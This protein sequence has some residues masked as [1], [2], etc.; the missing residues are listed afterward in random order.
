MIVITR[1]QYIALQIVADL[2]PYPNPPVKEDVQKH[3]LEL[4]TILKP[5]FDDP[6]VEHAAFMPLIGELEY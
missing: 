3:A 5:H 1:Q 6:D 4:M 2:W